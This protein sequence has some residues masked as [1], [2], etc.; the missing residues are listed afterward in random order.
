MNRL[1]CFQT[2]QGV[3]STYGQVRLLEWSIDGWKS[4]PGSR[5]IAVCSGCRDCP[6]FLFAPRRSCGGYL[7]LSVQPHS[8]RM[9]VIYHISMMSKWEPAFINQVLVTIV[10]KGTSLKFF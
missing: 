4:S 9:L 5:C 7:V 1:E 8:F 2:E 3:R 6:M 10:L